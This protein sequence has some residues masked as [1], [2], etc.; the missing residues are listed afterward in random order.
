[1]GLDSAHLQNY[2][3]RFHSPA[4]FFAQEY[5]AFRVTVVPF[6]ID[7]YEVT[8]ADF[9]KFIDA[10]PQWSKSKIPDSLQDGNYLKDWNGNKYPKLKGKFPVV[11]VSWYAANAYARWKGKRLPMEVELECAAKGLNDTPSYPWGNTDADT[12]KANYLPSHVGHPV[13]AGSYPPNSLGL[14]DMAGNVSEFCMDRWRTN[15]YTNKQK[16]KGG[17]VVIPSLA[18]DKNKVLIRGGS[19]NSPAAALLTI[20]RESFPANGCSGEVGFRCAVSV[21]TTPN[22][23]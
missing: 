16:F 23:K 19:W 2:I 22:P 5:P 8:N 15:D 14:Y 7:K 12:T 10:N 9:K 21:P 20:H 6:Y 18:E 17:Y 4:S 13:K 3:Q 1:M 11:Y